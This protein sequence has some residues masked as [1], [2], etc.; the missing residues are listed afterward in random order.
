MIEKVITK[1]KNIMSTIIKKKKRFIIQKNDYYLYAEMINDSN[2]VSYRVFDGKCMQPYSEEC[3]ED[4]FLPYKAI[5]LSTFLRIAIDYLIQYRASDRM[6]DRLY[7]KIERDT[8]N[9]IDIFNMIRF[10]EINVRPNISYRDHNDEFKYLD[11]LGYVNG[12]DFVQTPVSKVTDA[13]SSNEKTQIIN[14]EED[15]DYDLRR[16]YSNL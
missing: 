5:R 4:A 6:A 8:C 16:V 3:F 10:N 9:T 15:N 7:T 13:I 14:R 11:D 2:G 12:E 1:T